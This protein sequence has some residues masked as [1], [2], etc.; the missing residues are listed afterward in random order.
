[1]LLRRVTAREKLRWRWRLGS[2]Q[3]LSD[4][5]EGLVCLNYHPKVEMRNRCHERSKH[6]NMGRECLWMLSTRDYSSSHQN[7]FLLLCNKNKVAQ[8]G[9]IRKEKK[10]MKLV[11]AINTFPLQVTYSHLSFVKPK[12]RRFKASKQTQKTS[13]CKCQNSYK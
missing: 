1:M 2:S 11:S 3:V 4:S 5:C 9:K 8:R 12:M 7:F 10:K 6:V 13:I